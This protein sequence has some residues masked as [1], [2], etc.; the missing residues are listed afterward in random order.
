MIKYNRLLSA[1]VVLMLIFAMPGMPDLVTKIYAASSVSELFDKYLDV[2]IF[3]YSDPLQV[4]KPHHPPPNPPA[5][6]LYLLML[7]LCSTKPHHHLPKYLL[8]H[9]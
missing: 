4:P 1:S 5:L 7:I 6:H 9:L 2:P 3:R 8:L